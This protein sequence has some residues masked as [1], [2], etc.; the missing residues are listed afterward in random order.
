MADPLVSDDTVV[1]VAAPLPLDA[2]HPRSGYPP[3]LLGVAALVDHPDRMGMSMIPS[4]DPLQPVPQ[5]RL[6]PGQIRK[7]ALQRPRRDSLQ[8]VCRPQVIP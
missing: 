3:A 6:V 2:G 4:H 1:R 8:A 7:E 5:M